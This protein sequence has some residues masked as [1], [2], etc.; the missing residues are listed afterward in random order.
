MGLPKLNRFLPSIT[1]LNAQK[2]S[3]AVAFQYPFSSPRLTC[4]FPS[5]FGSGT[6]N[7]SSDSANAPP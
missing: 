7:R 2:H 1:A 6:F 5:T 4:V 3:E